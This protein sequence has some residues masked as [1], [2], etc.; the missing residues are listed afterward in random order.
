MKIKQRTSNFSPFFSVQDFQHQILTLGRFRH[1]E[2]ETEVENLEI[3]HPDLEIKENY[4]ET[5]TDLGTKERHL[6][7]LKAYTF[8]FFVISDELLG[9]WRS[10]GRHWGVLGAGFWK[11]LASM[12]LR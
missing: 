8:L 12:R 4:P 3:L 10:F 1:G 7:T 2:S 6:E 9:V 11:M 5:S